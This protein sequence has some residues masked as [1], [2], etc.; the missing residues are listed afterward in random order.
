M[1]KIKRSRELSTKSTLKSA[2]QPTP[3]R[4][5]V[6]KPETKISPVRRVRTSDKS[7]QTTNQSPKI[8]VEQPQAT[9]QSP[10]IIVEQPQVTIQPPQIIVEQLHETHPQIPIQSP[11]VTSGQFL[12][13]NQGMMILQPIKMMSGSSLAQTFL[14][15]LIPGTHNIDT[16]SPNIIMLPQSTS[17]ISGI[18]YITPESSRPIMLVHYQQLG[19]SQHHQIIMTQPPEQHLISP[20]IHSKVLPFVNTPRCSSK[21]QQIS[22]ELLTNTYTVPVSPII[23][24]PQPK[25]G[26][27]QSPQIQGMP[28]SILISPIKGISPSV[29][30]PQ[31]KNISPSV[32]IPQPKNISPSVLISPIKGVSPSV[33]ISSIKGV[34][35]SV[36]IPQPKNISPSVLIPPIKNTL[37]LVP[38]TTSTPLSVLIPQTK[39]ASPNISIPIIPTP[40]FTTIFPIQTPNI[41]PT[42]TATHLH[43]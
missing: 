26:I 11:Q 25:L 8:I 23:T 28:P 35:P 39:N 16:Q 2:K 13:L 20:L 29:L 12:K 43:S 33:L 41:V 7:Q 1:N 38:P 15:T 4:Q 14:A 31:P 21:D 34:S 18:T 37:L 17:I 10:K 36:L 42:H 40:R 19:S 22:S 30:I 3:V 32:L 24:Y 6:I 9:T 27:L 5:R